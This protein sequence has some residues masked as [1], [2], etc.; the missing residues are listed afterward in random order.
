MEQLMNSQETINVETA[1]PD[2]DAAIDSSIEQMNSIEQEI[3]KILGQSSVDFIEKTISKYLGDDYKSVD[4]GLVEKI[5]LILALA[6]KKKINI[7]QGMLRAVKKI[8][9]ILPDG[10][11]NVAYLAR[12]N[13][14]KRKH[15]I[16]VLSSLILLLGMSFGLGKSLITR[17]RNPDIKD[18]IELSSS[19]VDSKNSEALEAELKFERMYSDD[20]KI[21]VAEVGWE[22]FLS[23]YATSNNESIWPVKEVF[24]LLRM[25]EPRYWG[26]YVVKYP[27]VFLSEISDSKITLVEFM[28]SC[29][30]DL[31]FS[32]LEE[33][34]DADVSWLD[35]WNIDEMFETLKI[36]D[37]NWGKIVFRNQ[38]LFVDALD[39]EDLT[40]LI[41]TFSADYRNEISIQIFLRDYDSGWDQ[42]WSRRELL[43]AMKEDN[44]TLW[45]IYVSDNSNFFANELTLEELSEIIEAVSFKNSGY[46]P[47]K[48]DLGII[49]NYYSSR[50]YTI[51]KPSEFVQIIETHFSKDIAEQI[52]AN[53]PEISGLKN[54]SIDQLF[55][56][57]AINYVLDNYDDW[58]SIYSIDGIMTFLR[59]SGNKYDYKLITR[60]PQLFKNIDFTDLEVAYL[61]Y[62]DNPYEISSGKTY[63]FQNFLGESGWQNQISIDRLLTIG[64][65]DPNF[66]MYSTAFYFPEIFLPNFTDEDMYQLVIYNGHNLERMDL[67]NAIDPVWLSLISE[68]SRRNV[69]ELAKQ[70]SENDWKNLVTSYPYY[71]DDILTFDEAKEVL[72]KNYFSSIRENQLWQ[73]NITPEWEYSFF[74]ES[75][76]DAFIYIITS[77]PSRFSNQL[78][79]DDKLMILKNNPEAILKNYQFWKQSFSPEFILDYFHKSD[80]NYGSLVLEYKQ[81]FGHVFYNDSYSFKELITHGGL[82]ILFDVNYDVNKYYY[83][84]WSEF[85]SLEEIFYIL[86]DTDN[87]RDKILTK[88][89]LFFEFVEFSDLDLFVQS[90]YGILILLDYYDD[91]RELWSLEDIY[92]ATKANDVS[93]SANVFFS[94]EYS[95]NFINFITRE[96]LNFLIGTYNDDNSYMFRIDLEIFSRKWT[97]EEILASLKQEHPEAWGAFVTADSLFFDALISKND[98]ESL[99]RHGANPSGLMNFHLW[100]TKEIFDAYKD[101]LPEKWGR[102]ILEN[103]GI[104]MDE[105]VRRNIS[106]QQLLQ[107]SGSTNPIEYLHLWYSIWSEDEIKAAIE[108]EFP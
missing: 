81:I 16:Q 90:P 32:N 53:Y 42:K 59:I 46:L 27:K 60:Y 39:R 74:K 17:V 108:A 89:N 25:Q 65:E 98:L 102:V 55:E 31:F 91:W 56:T 13:E 30:A 54:I 63:F 61:A 99:V 52:L 69:L 88:S 14:T 70:D 12:L 67:L 18:K 4:L 33:Q 86:K 75:G 85:T 28:S 94:S 36:T 22:V 93:Y 97:D 96:D 107:A 15:L 87:G 106:L 71:F 26:Q 41:H 78:E 48:S 77:D 5:N 79:W 8:N 100:E 20:L 68:E 38:K 24:Q 6:S 10:Q 44:T 9:T 47:A 95:S 29:D 45:K 64:R 73:S 104:F 40:T 72:N 43:D 1:D 11:I 51:A 80:K 58:E 35:L 2:Q 23:K 84:E 37:P 34:I 3:K 92:R 82:D 57:Q 105:V 66:G 62:M 7:S 21:A 49:S 103:P 76:T 83:E 101:W 19:P 50:L